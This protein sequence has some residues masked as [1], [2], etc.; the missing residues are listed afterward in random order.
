MSDPVDELLA[1]FRAD[2]PEPDDA[3]RARAFARATAPRR[4]RRPVL[5][6]VGFAVVAAAVAVALVAPGHRAASAAT[7]LERVAAATAPPQ[8]GIVH[9]RYETVGVPF[10]GAGKTIRVTVESWRELGGDRRSRTVSGAIAPPA[11][12]EIFGGKRPL[13][14]Y[15]PRTN[16]LYDLA[17]RSVLPLGPSSAIG[18]FGQS[19]STLRDQLESGD[20]ADTWTVTRTTLDGRDVYRIDHRTTGDTYEIRALYVDAKTYVPVRIDESGPPK[21]QPGGPYTQP[22]RSFT[23]GRHYPPSVSVTTI[24]TYETL[25]DGSVALDA[26]AVHPGARELPVSELRPDVAA[27][28]VGSGPTPTQPPVPPAP[29]ANVRRLVV[30]P[31]AGAIGSFHVG[32]NVLAASAVLPKPFADVQVPPGNLR[33]GHAVGGLDASGAIVVTFSDANE[34]HSTSAYLSQPFRTTRGDESGSTT[35]AE[36]LARWPEHEEPQA[37]ARGTTRVA[38]G[39]ATF[40]FDAKGVLAAVIV[41]DV[42]DAFFAG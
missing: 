6:A 3:Q 2:V 36:L 11:T 4:S 14:L 8:S 5:L 24:E 33:V 12:V 22:R 23:V 17:G 31:L 18:G 30:D 20:V 37:A 19:A 16:G 13:Q 29:P 7:I 21:D 34:V 39:K 32:A 28:V 42:R 9:L 26:A 10:A 41:G 25:A 35:L 15:D 1:T 27:Q 40:V 38:V